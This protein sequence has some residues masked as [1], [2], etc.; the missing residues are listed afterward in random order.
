[1]MQLKERV[2]LCDGESEFVT[3]RELE[4]VSVEVLDCV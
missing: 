3:E 1:M 4:L 2:G